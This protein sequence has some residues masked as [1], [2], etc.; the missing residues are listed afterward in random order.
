MKKIACI[1][2]AGFATGGTEKALQNIA[3]TLA[4]SKKY[5][6]DYYYTN[7][8][9]FLN[10]NFVHPDNSL[11]QKKW[12][13]SY[14][15]KSI[16][17]FVE[18]KI[19]NKSPFEWNNTNFW[20]L[21]KE[22]DYDV[23]QTARGGYTE[24]PFNLINHTPI[25]DGIHSDAGE[26]K[27]NIK[28]AILISKWQADK[29]AS[30]GGNIKKAVIIPNL[31]FVPEKKPSTLR[32][33]LNIPEDAF[34]F[35]FHQRND[36]AL[37][38][39]VA[40]QAYQHIQKENVY[41]VL[42]G[43]S[44]RHRQYAKENNLKNVYFLNFTPDLNEIHDFLEGIDVYSHSRLDGEVCSVAII[45]AMSHGKPIVTHPGTVSMG[46]LEQIEGCGYMAYN[47][48]EYANKLKLI[49]DNKEIY[50]AMSENTLNKYFE[51]YSY[52][53]VKQQIIDLYS[54]VL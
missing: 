12:V 52:H 23:I 7:A 36:P 45:E 18:S 4:E 49:K 37:F 42:L 27:P 19:G 31:V 51:K 1:K 26:D 9:P 5:H 39:P 38:S 47:V 32:S 28:K 34:V 24:Y 40:L 21:F 48:E 43:G 46:H 20:N 16:P 10:C 15:V 8:A 6:V 22:S 35:G 54:E 44:D 29:W 53:K 30:N 3:V 33:R 50:S 14:G 2:F 25:I 17:V 41:F 11:E 13:E